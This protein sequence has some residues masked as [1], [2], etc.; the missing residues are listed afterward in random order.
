MEFQKEVGK[1]KAV[2][3]IAF[4][5]LIQESEVKEIYK[6]N[7]FLAAKGIISANNSNLDYY[8]AFMN[9]NESLNAF[10]EKVTN[11]RKQ[12][13]YLDLEA[14]AYLLYLYN[15]LMELT[16]YIIANDPHVNLHTWG[17]VFFNDILNWA[18]NTDKAITKDINKAG[19]L[20]ETH[21]GKRW[22]KAKRR[23]NN[24]LNKKSILRLLQFDDNKLSKKE[25]EV[26]HYIL[27]YLDNSISI[28]NSTDESELQETN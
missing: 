18:Q 16:S 25:L 26:K 23:V 5:D 3:L 6:I 27:N 7:T 11:L 13:K 10:I 24:K 22:E 1:K 9:D 4:K 21:R 14:S 12:E 17:V 2:T 8:P 15:Y 20:L 19:I 28:D